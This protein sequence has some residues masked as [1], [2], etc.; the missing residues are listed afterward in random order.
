MVARL[1]KIILIL[2]TALAMASWIPG[3]SVIGGSGDSPIMYGEYDCYLF[4]Y[5]ENTYIEVEAYDNRGVTLYLLDLDETI[6]FLQN[7]SL[8]EIGVIPLAENV[9]NYVGYMPLQTRGW[10]CIIITP[11]HEM[12]AYGME[13]KRITPH[14]GLLLV[15][16][17]LVSIGVVLVIRERQKSRGRS[18]S[19]AVSPR[20]QFLSMLAEGRHTPDVRG[21]DSA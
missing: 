3:A 15:S 2:G 16:I 5:T 1:A 4:K 18:Q 10:Y 7:E 9:T 11:Y 13:M 19:D 21:T 14:L 12:A 17:T 20:E 6:S 8:D